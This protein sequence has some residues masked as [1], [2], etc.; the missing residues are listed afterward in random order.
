[1]ADACQGQFLTNGGGWICE[2]CLLGAVDKF[3][4]GCYPKSKL[5]GQG[6]GVMETV[7]MGLVVYVFLVQTAGYAVKGLIGFGNPVLTGPLLS[8]RLDNAVISPAGLL[9]DGPANAYIAWK[10]RKNFDWRRILPLTAAVLLGV[11]PGTL[12]LK[13]SL[14]W[15]IKAVLG[16]LVIGIGVEMATR[17][18]RPAGRDRPVLRYGVAFV[19]GVFAGLYGINLLIVAYLERTAQDHSAFKGSLCFLFLTENLYRTALYAATGIFT[20]ESL[21]LALLTVPAAVLGLWLGGRA[22]AHLSRQKVQKGVILLFLLSGVSVLVKAL[23][24]HS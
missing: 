23:L 1:M 6:E 7:T 13:A 21:L 4:A 8:L 19:S 22:E 15:V 24:F 20:R 12:L 9:I 2:T 11:L 14:P 16:L 3:R 18:G 5:T 10:N 17:G